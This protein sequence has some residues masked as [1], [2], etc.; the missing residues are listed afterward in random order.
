MDETPVSEKQISNSA[1]RQFVYG[2]AYTQDLGMAPRL[3]DCKNDVGE[4][5]VVREI[6]AP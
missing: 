5:Y 2:V 3:T 4:V 6:K 1:Y